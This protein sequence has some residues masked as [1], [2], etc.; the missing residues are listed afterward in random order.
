MLA[1]LKKI[2]GHFVH[3]RLFKQQ[4]KY[5]NKLRKKYQGID[6]Y[7]RLEYTI[8]VQTHGIEKGLSFRTPKEAFGVVKIM[9]LID[10]LKIYIKNP[11]YNK[12]SVNET[13]NVLNTYINKFKGNSKITTI[14]KEY[15][16]LLAKF[17]TINQCCVGTMTICKKDVEEAIDIDYLK[18]IKARHSYRYFTRD[19]SIEQIKQ[20]LEIARYTPTAC[21]RQPQ[22]VHIYQ[23]KE[24]EE[25]LTIQHG[26]LGFI[27]EMSYCI[28][29]TAD[30]RA[31]SHMENYQAYVDGGLY[32]MNLLNALHSTGL[33]T[34]PLT[35][36]HLQGIGRQKLA[37]YGVKEYECPI[38]VIGIGGLEEKAEV[39]VSPRKEYSDYTTFHT[40]EK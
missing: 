2:Y 8:K 1:I 24:M 36:G 25:V 10:N 20:A 34:I 16:E 40:N 38:I 14:E 26:A 33:G 23:G 15:N 28:L 22:C 39:N 17:G 32:A 30:M 4:L 12:E 31:Y 27:D 9:A 11:K 18:F 6:N 7:T 37:K 13:L 19:A 29:I 35:C 5:Q 3:Q 21:N